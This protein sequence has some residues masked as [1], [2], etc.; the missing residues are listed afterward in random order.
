[1]KFKR[2]AK[3]HGYG[4]ALTLL[5]IL[6]TK[7]I[8]AAELL[9]TRTAP[10]AIPAQPLPSALAQYSEQS[11]VQVTSSSDL[12]EKKPSTGVAGRTDAQTAL[13]KILEGT[14]LTFE[15]IDSDSVIIVPAK[16]RV[17]PVATQKALSSA[18]RGQHLSEDEVI[19]TGS[20]IRGTRASASTV[21][22]FTQLDFAASGATSIQAFMRTI[23][24]AFNGGRS[25]ASAAVRDY[26]NGGRDN[27]TQGAGINIRGLGNESTLVLLNGRRMAPG[28]F[29][30]FYDVSSIALSA[31]ERIDVLPDGSS[32]IYGSDAIGGVVN[33]ILRNSFDGVESTVGYGSVTEGDMRE[34]TAGQLL[35]TK[36]NRGSVLL[37]LDYLHRDELRARD[38]D[39]GVWKG[40]T[41]LLPQEK[42]LSAL[43]SAKQDLA[44][45]LRLSLDA[46]VTDRDTETDTGTYWV[47]NQIHVDA[48]SVHVGGT[49]GLAWTSNN[50]W[51]ISLA[52]TQ[53]RSE[54]LRRNHLG[55]LEPHYAWVQTQLGISGTEV[56]MYGPAFSG[57]G[58]L[59]R[60]AIGAERRRESVDVTRFNIPKVSPEVSLSR[61]VDSA[62][63]ELQIPLLASL[64]GRKLFEA[65][66]AVR[67]EDY[68]DVGATDNTKLS[69]VWSPLRGIDL[70]A[71]WGTSFRAPYL[72]QYDTTFGT[73]MLLFAP[74]SASQSGSIV[75]AVAAA[76]PRPDLGPETATT[77]TAGF[78]VATDL[79]GALRMSGTYF[80]VDYNN[81]ISEPLPT[82][83]AFSEPSLIPLIS[84]PPDPEVLE[85]VRTAP[86][87]YDFTGL[88]ID[89]VEATL[90]TR[91]NNR[92]SAKVSGIDLLLASEFQT[93]FGTMTAGINANYFLTFETRVTESSP[94]HSILSTVFNPPDFRARW[95]IQWARS[96]FTVSAFVNYVDNNIDDQG[97]KRTR[98]SS[99]T[100]FDIGGTYDFPDT[101]GWTRGLTI[102]ANVLNA[103]DRSPPHIRDRA[104]AYGDPGYDTHNANP[105]GRFVSFQITKAW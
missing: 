51:E 99:W 52:H 39:F 46:Y 69:A 43:V 23:P 40:N 72:Y 32:A 104:G 30:S 67:Y 49:A 24:Q 4:V 47:A 3:R 10:F 16:T 63:A 31:V 13:K 75:M 83:Q 92:S 79:L 29:G 91:T 55:D 37:N 62:Y 41:D 64:D 19:V 48:E 2:L 28:G 59:S 90:D 22:S 97:P 35:G 57:P 105:L 78:S 68:A 33:I 58:G 80:H 56:K 82:E 71:T 76:G 70:R 17:Q 6:S 21:L 45:S 87:F 93:R 9:L 25:E 100:T 102:R 15:V 85:W 73:G 7:S 42:R 98:V 12:I 103:T 20:H 86:S 84:T 74:N 27:L 96:D 53:G 38:R 5:C 77:W 34:F 101:S 94:S 95:Q 60:L 36:W 66:A 1:M 11:G 18:N 26:R 89:A 54:N 65:A 14:D 88:G 81:R 44:S 50:D 8:V 61:T